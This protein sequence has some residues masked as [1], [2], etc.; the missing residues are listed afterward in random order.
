MTLFENILDRLGLQRR[1]VPAAPDKQQPGDPEDADPEEVRGAISSSGSTIMDWMRVAQDQVAR[2]K[3]YDDMD[4]TPELSTAFDTYADEATQPDP[5]TRRR[6]WVE[7]SA[8]NLQAELDALLKLH[9]EDDLWDIA[10]EVVKN[11]NDFE[12]LRLREK[13]GLI[14]KA[15]RDVLAMSRIEYGGRLLGFCQS[16]YG[17][18]GISPD[19]IIPLL[20]TRQAQ[21][22]D[23]VEDDPQAMTAFEPFE[24]VHTRI[25]GRRRGSVYGV[26]IA[27]GARSAFRRLLMVEDASLVGRIARAPNRYAFYVDVGNATPERALAAVKEFSRT[28]KRAEFI[29]KT[30]GRLN[31]RW[32]PLAVDEDFFIPV[33]RGRDSVRVDVLNSAYQA[34]TEDLKWW[35]NKIAIAVKIP[36]AWSFSSDEG[37]AMA[38]RSLIQQ[39]VRFARTILR[40]QQAMIHGRREMIDRHLLVTGREPADTPYSLRMMIPSAIFELAAMEVLSAKLDVVARMTNTHSIRWILRYLFQFSD[41]GIEEMLGQLRDDALRRGTIEGLEDKG[42]ALATGAPAGPQPQFNS[43][44]PVGGPAIAAALVE[45]T[46]STR[47]DPDHAQSLREAEELRRSI[48]GLGRKI[49]NVQRLL[50]DVKS[51]VDAG[52][53]R[54]WQSILPPSRAGAFPDSLTAEREGS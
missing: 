6:I 33:A 50:G 31:T 7:A 47:R 11:G 38:G 53:H 5:L 48:G 35:Q 43:L 46:R 40:I 13:I 34:S 42:R 51:T 23:F 36:L 4:G 25:R 54:P 28:I 3:D 22:L 1:V 29:D 39:D 45:S 30:T 9:A 17:P 2:Y 21:P 44:D 32:N 10:R 26:G 27:E 14:A 8:G 37:G 16:E 20:K 18:A 24:V 15:P 41:D 12:V 49:A 19:T 52:A